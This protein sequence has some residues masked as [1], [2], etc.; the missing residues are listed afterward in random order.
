M[1]TLGELFSSRI[2]ASVLAYLVAREEARFSL[3]ELS[4]ALDLSVS[5]IQHECYKLE[6][7]GVLKGRREGAS[8]RY[9]LDRDQPFVPVLMWL[10]VTIIGQPQVLGYA[11]HG[12]DGL[13]G[14]LLTTDG[15]MP[16]L[17]LIG[18]LG[19]D[20]LAT[21]QDRVSKI[22]DVPESALNVAFYDLATWQ[23]YI[24]QQHPSIAAIRSARPEILAGATDMFKGLF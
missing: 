4:R 13:E 11:L 2:R 19:L 24:A 20:E 1:D 9:W 21:V 5:S 8:R 15:N 23:S 12:I 18:E 14:A 16:T 22:L 6:R 3:T 10:V 17:T 7:L